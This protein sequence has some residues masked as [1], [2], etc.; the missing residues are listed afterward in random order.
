MRRVGKAAT[1]WW[2]VQRAG[3]FERL[4]PLGAL[5]YIAEALQ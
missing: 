3:R 4:I 5:Q 1:L 2:T